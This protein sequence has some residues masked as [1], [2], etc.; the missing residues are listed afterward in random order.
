MN[1]FVSTITKANAKLTI[2]KELARKE[3]IKWFH[4]DRRYQA[5]NYIEKK[6]AL[7]DHMTISELENAIRFIEEMKI[8]TENQKTEPFKNVLSKDFHYRTMASFEVDDFPTSVKRSQKSES[9]VLINKRSSLCSFLADIH[10]TLISHYELSKA[11]TDGHIPVSTIYYT[12]DLLK[13]TQIAQDIVNTTKAAT[14][15]DEST[16]VMDIRRGGTT[17]YGVKIDTGKNDAY[18]IPTIE[19]FTGDKIDILGSKANKIFNF[20][21]QVLH[22]IILDEFENSMEL[23]DGSQHLTEG[24]KP[25]LTRGRVNWSKNSETGQIYA[26]V[27]LRILACAFIDPIDTTK[28]PKHFAIR[29]DGITLDTIDESMLPHLNR[30]A[31][32]DEND[33]V[34]ICTFRAKLDMTQDPRNQGHYLRMNEFVVKINTSDMI[35]RKDPNHQPKSSWYYDV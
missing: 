14:T 1:E 18:A 11:H 32:Q 2:F 13:Q 25:T 21:G 3:S 10:S 24:L 34:P 33:I 22:G 5:I 16:C 4:D 12:P 35:S 30:V 8:T 15:S 17:F 19:N 6:L 9:T 20:G 23:I 7:H 27:E 31:T 26:T 29:S 28:M